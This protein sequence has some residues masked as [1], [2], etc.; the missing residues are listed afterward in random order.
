M[1]FR[2]L[3]RAQVGK[4]HSA[5][6]VSGGRAYTMGWNGHEDTVWCLD[7]ATGKTIW[8]QS[9]PCRTILQWPGPRAT[10]T[11]AGDTVYTLG[12]HGQL[13]AWH[14]VTGKPVWKVQLPAQYNPDVDYGFAWSP[15]LEADLLILGT[16]S[17]G[18]AVRQ[19][20]G[21]FAWGND[22]KFGACVSPVPHVF[23]GKR[24]V[25]VVTVNPDRHSSMVVGVEAQTGKELWRYGPWN[26][27]WGAICADLLIDG[28]KVMITSAEEHRYAARFSIGG[29]NA[30]EDWRSR[31]FASYTGSCVLI[32]GH[33]YGV[34]YQG[35]LKC[36]EWNTGQVKWQQRDFGRHGT[37]M[38]ADGKLLV[39]NSKSGELH[40]VE[41][42][43]AGYKELRRA[44][45]FN[46]G[47][48]DTFTVPVLSNGRIY[49]R[50]YDGQ[51][52]CLSADGVAK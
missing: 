48:T 22:G 29:A 42:T 40:I 7:A 25:A 31:D 28:G 26:E 45:V 18:L 41:A 51:V 52:V 38:A 6:A 4:G 43:P 23:D 5:I 24:A 35:A 37:L 39:Q 20:D 36:L 16:G 30:K 32:D 13:N 21:S 49:C 3:W 34:H 8:K 9:Y 11:V 10:P 46:E 44:E 19:K 47:G 1:L 17:R 14:A 2:S 15:L 33:V 27:K 12:Q 50:S